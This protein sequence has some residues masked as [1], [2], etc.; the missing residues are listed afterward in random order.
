M[1]QGKVTELPEDTGGYVVRA[2]ANDNYRL[3]NRLF[4]AGV[5]VQVISYQDR[6]KDITGM[7]VPCGSLF[8]SDVNNVSSEASELLEGI[9]TVLTGGADE[10]VPGSVQYSPDGTRISYIRD[11]GGDHELRIE[12]HR[13][14]EVGLNV[15]VVQLHL[16]VDGRGELG[17]RLRR[18]GCPRYR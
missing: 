5:P 2:G 16:G 17:Q 8:I 14:F 3:I 7:E 13:L 18:N 12:F 9:S 6:W 10:I 4:K 1:P 11:R 15:V